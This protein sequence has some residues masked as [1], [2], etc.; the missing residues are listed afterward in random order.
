MRGW[1]KQ[2]V[3]KIQKNWLSINMLGIIQSLKKNQP[4]IISSHRII[5]LSALRKA[6][7]QQIYVCSKPFYRKVSI[8]IP[9]LSL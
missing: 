2:T 7:G 3:Y 4:A 9:I 8:A 6:I 1:I 5:I